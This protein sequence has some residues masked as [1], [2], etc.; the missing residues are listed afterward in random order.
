MK[1]ISFKAPASVLNQFEDLISYLD[2]PARGKE[3]RDEI[4]VRAILVWLSNQEVENFTS[5]KGDDNTPKGFL[6]LLG[7][8]RSTY[9]SIFALL[10]RYL[11]A[12]LVLCYVK[13]T[14]TSIYL[15]LTIIYL[16]EIIIIDSR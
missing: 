13:D 6:S 9:P 16:V 3:S 11:S 10:C 8:K 4:M 7:L 5:M 12:M 14:F 1:N 2:K 15:L